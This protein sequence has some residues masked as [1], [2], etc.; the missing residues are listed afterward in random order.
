MEKKWVPLSR[1]KLDGPFPQSR[2]QKTKFILDRKDEFDSLIIRKYDN[3]VKYFIDQ[4]EVDEWV[5]KIT[6]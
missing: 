6:N 5:K 2:Q 1:V 4:N 3:S